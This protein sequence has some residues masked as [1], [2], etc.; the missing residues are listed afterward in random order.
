MLIES[1][2]PL[3]LQINPLSPN[4]LLPSFWGMEEGIGALVDSPHILRPWRVSEKTGGK[5]SFDPHYSHPSLFLSSRRK[6]WA[7][8]HKKN[9]ELAETCQRR[10]SYFPCPSKSHPLTLFSK[11][12]KKSF[13]LSAIPRLICRNFLSCEVFS[14]D[15][16][17]SICGFNSGSEASA[18]AIKAEWSNSGVAICCWG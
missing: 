13:L 12:E 5:G 17:H 3:H 1:L 9:E 8:P 2:L 11:C 10:K 14:G 15:F 16:L 4:L 7:F 6:D 18:F